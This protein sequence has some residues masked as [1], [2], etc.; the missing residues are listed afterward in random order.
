ME[1]FK[2]IANKIHTELQKIA[3]DIVVNDDYK[4]I[5]M[6]ISK[7]GLVLNISFNKDNLD[8]YFSFDYQANPIDNDVI[9]ERNSSIYKISEDVSEIFE[10]KMFTSSYLNK[11]NK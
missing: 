9:V 10:K 3:S 4:T 5:N 11:V 7:D 6:S 2:E 1:K 8:N